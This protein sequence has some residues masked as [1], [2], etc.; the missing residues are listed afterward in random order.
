M[1]HTC[2]HGGRRGFTLLEL[3]I[4]VFIIGI[5][6]AIALPQLVPAIAFS[7]LEG[8]A[9]HLA[10]YGRAAIAEATLRRAKVVVRFDFDQQEYYAVRWEI[11][12]T[13]EGAEDSED[14]LSKIMGLRGQ[15]DFGSD[16][17]RE[18]LSQAPA[19][20]G[21]GALADRRG[22]GLPEGFDSERANEQMMDRFN[23]FARS[24]TEE[25]A[26]NVIP[27]KG[28]LDEIGPL[29]D[30]EEEFTLDAM[31]P[32]EVE[33]RDPIIQRTRL[34]GPVR[35]DSIVIDGAASSRGIV[36][37]E[38]SPLGLTS[39]VCLYLVNDDGDYYTIIWDPLT[40]G[41]RAKPGQEAHGQSGGW[42]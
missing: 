12:D 15:M 14:H 24:I 5:I 34:P 32:E 8:A 17:F 18:M 21:A 4:V 40:G 41:A 13:G 20:V 10:N 31:Q 28:F 36:E 27:D 11:P 23:R 1:I 19:P 37:V 26:K 6:A 42:S 22:L 35:L 16:A 7:E 30:P 2:H 3:A 38:L 29:F 39:E 9:R 25:Q 33:I